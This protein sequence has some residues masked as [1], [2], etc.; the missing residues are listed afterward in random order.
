MDQIRR[1][2]G[3]PARATSTTT[4]LS[5]NRSP[6]IRQQTRRRRAATQRLPIL[7]CGCADPWIHR[8]R[9]DDPT[10]ARVAGY[11]A[12][13]QLLDELG[14][15]AAPLVPELRAMWRQGDRHL[16]ASVT[17]RWAVA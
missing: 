4:P 7:G 14:Y 3:A 12:T 2:P 9:R 10:P 11:A 17:T 5:S 8:C 6:E 15:P 1:S 16:V 13:V